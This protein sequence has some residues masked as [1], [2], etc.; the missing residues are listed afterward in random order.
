MSK[1]EDFFHPFI[2][3]DDFTFIE[4][5]HF[6]CPNMNKKKFF[7]FDKSVIS[8]ILCLMNTTLEY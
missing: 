2:E 6:S 5:I 7:E 3:E 1:S 8:I 4:E